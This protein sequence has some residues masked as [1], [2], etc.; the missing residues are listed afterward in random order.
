MKEDCNGVKE[1]VKLKKLGLESPVNKSRQCV[2][3]AA[4]S[5]HIGLIHPI[6]ETTIE[7]KKQR[8]EEKTISW[9]EEMLHGL[10]IEQTKKLGSQDSSNGCDMGSQSM[11]QKAWYVLPKNKPFELM[12]LT[13]HKSKWN[14]ECVVEPMRQVTTL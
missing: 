7:A 12:A 13:N 10:F 3:T 11:K 2:L 9:K 8:K 14:A 6:W 1:T 5:A 4:R